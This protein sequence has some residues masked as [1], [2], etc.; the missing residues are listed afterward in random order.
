MVLS[1]SMALRAASPPRHAGVR[2]LLLA[3]MACASVAA[4]AQAVQPQAVAAAH[5]AGVLQLQAQAS[6]DVLPDRTLARLAAVA[7]GDDVAVLNAQVAERIAA[8]VRRARGV[9]GVEAGIGTIG[10]Q[11]RWRDVGGATR[12][13]G[14]TVTA[15]LKLRSADTAALARLIGELSST[16]QIQSVQAEVSPQLRER[17]LVELSSRAI[18][19]FR[20]RAQAAAHDFGYTGYSVREVQLSGLEGAEP[21]PHPL[22]M[23]A[24]LLGQGAPAPAVPLD[25]ST[26]QLSVS[27]SGSVQLQR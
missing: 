10:T 4:Q 27:V 9:A 3:A 13:D 22:M 26:R 7:Q 11:P 1:R 2:M 5:D 25:P 20:A 6:A 18:A 12:Q 23:R 14:W 21:Q 15:E 24:G 16:L 17:E 8:A 19:A